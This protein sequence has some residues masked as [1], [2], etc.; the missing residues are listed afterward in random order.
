MIIVKTT[1]VGCGRMY[2]LGEELLQQGR[3]NA[4]VFEIVI[5][6][7]Y[8]AKPRPP[9]VTTPGGRGFAEILHA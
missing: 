9:G 5:K 7:S 6:I 4:P 2:R 1:D 8:S 3:N